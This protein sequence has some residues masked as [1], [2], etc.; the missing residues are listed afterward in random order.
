MNT[1]VTDPQVWQR[2][3]EAKRLAL[4]ATFED[5]VTGLR[6]KEFCQRLSC[7]LGQQCQIVEHVWLFGTFRLRELQEIAAEEA[8]VSDLVIIS[9]HEAEGLPDEVKSWIDLWLSHKGARHAVL[10]AL[11]DSPYGEASGSIEA[12]LQDIARRGGME[13]LVDS[14]E[15]SAPRWQER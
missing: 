9:V 6:V 15:A 3:K 2:W 7:N 12:Y 10:L 4:L 14:R 11:L 1:S 5:S 13:F 8:S